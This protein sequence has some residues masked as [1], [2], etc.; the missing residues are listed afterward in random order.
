MTRV[1]VQTQ[2]VGYASDWNLEST[3]ETLKLRGDSQR[4][5]AMLTFSPYETQLQDD[6]AT[7]WYTYGDT[8]SAF[9]LGAV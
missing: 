1:E 9:D 6:A 3:I 2:P 7:L 4:M 8:L 5:D